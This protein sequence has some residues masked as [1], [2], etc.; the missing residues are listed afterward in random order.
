[1]IVSNAETT[2]VLVDAR[3]SEAGR[4]FVHATSVDEMDMTQELLDALATHVAQMLEAAL[5]MTRLVA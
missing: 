3:T 1:M 4:L 2:N 5:V